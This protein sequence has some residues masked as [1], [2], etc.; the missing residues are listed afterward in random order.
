MGRRFEEKK[1][2]DNIVKEEIVG[3]TVVGDNFAISNENVVSENVVVPKANVGV[4]IIIVSDDDDDKEVMGDTRDTVVAETD[5]EIDSVPV[6]VDNVVVDT[7]GMS[8]VIL[9]AYV[10]ATEGG[11]LEVQ[12]VSLE[13]SIENQLSNVKQSE[14]VGSQ[15]FIPTRKSQRIQNQKMS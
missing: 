12:Q 3:D 1:V 15:Q 14:N 11:S 2:A 4:K 6:D 13:G 8:R 7:V 5:D 9:E 10:G